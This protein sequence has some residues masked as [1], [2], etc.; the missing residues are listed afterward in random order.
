[1]LPVRDTVRAYNFPIINWTLIGLNTLGFILE[2]QFGPAGL[3]KFLQ[4]WG[5]VPARLL[6]GPPIVW[7]TLFTSMFL[8]GG[9][10]HF[11]SNMWFLYIF[12]DNVEDRMG[13]WRYLFFYLASGAAAGIMQTLV[14]PGSTLPTIG[15]S[16]AIAGVLG[17]YVLF[18][19]LANVTT[20]V[21]FFFFVTFVD[22]PA[23]LYLGFWFVSQFF[24]GLASL[25]G[26]QV[27]GVAWWAHVGGFVFGWLTGRFFAHRQPA[28]YR[29]YPDEYWPW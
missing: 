8:H 13:P 10:F 23:L 14:M 17:A 9:W 3:E 16:G 20:M 25:V 6:N 7:V 28:Y 15:A 22:I 26:P 1:M 29:W 11:L 19:P 27:G 5:L 2:L 24:S 21:F 4:V 12:G 18:Y